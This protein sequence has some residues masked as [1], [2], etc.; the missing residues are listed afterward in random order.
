MTLGMSSSAHRAQM[1]E[2]HPLATPT[3]VLEMDRLLQGYQADTT[4]RR[5]QLERN[6]T[7]REG[8]LKS[9]TSEVEEL[10]AQVSE[11]STTIKD[12]RDQLSQFREN[13]R[14]L[15]SGSQSQLLA[16]VSWGRRGELVTGL[17]NT[18]TYIQ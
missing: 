18:S 4:A 6:L 17:F 3:Q 1:C 15:F 16:K 10:S 8:E 13:Q 2:P 14:N 9:R 12:L 7:R 5:L 11:D